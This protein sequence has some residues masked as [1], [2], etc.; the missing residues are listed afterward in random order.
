MAI[1]GLP[2]IALQLVDIQM[3]FTM[4]F[5]NGEK[6]L[7]PK[8]DMQADIDLNTSLVRAAPRFNIRKPHE[9]PT[10]ALVVMTPEHNN[11]HNN[12]R[13]DA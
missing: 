3:R 12:N 4:K 1:I 9:I 5:L 10:L 6:R 2:F 13:I 7:P 8:A 11:H